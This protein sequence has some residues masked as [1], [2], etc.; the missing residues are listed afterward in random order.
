MAHCRIALKRRPLLRLEM[1]VRAQTGRADC[2][3]GWSRGPLLGASGS[4]APHAR[5]GAPAGRRRRR[6]QSELRGRGC[7]GRVVARSR[8]TALGHINFTRAASFPGTRSSR[9]LSP[10]RETFFALSSRSTFSEHEQRYQGAPFSSSQRSL[11]RPRQDIFPK[12][13]DPAEQAQSE[14]H[15]LLYAPLPAGARARDVSLDFGS[16]SVSLAI[17]GLEI[18]D[19]APLLHG[20]DTDGCGWLFEEILDD[21][22]GDD[23]QWL[24]A[25]LPKLNVGLI[26]PSFLDGRSPEARRADLTRSLEYNPDAVI[27]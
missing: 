3:A 27:I 15:I 25:E 1:I 16:L 14:G 21:D 7:A 18:F 10:S 11:F 4:P 26:W 24:V 23:T 22:T 2:Y 8:R 20:V 6:H 12:I 5:R 13:H 9:S 17:K 19:K